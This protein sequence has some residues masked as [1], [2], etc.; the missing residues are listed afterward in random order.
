VGD[1][2]GYVVVILGT[3]AAAMLC[4]LLHYE[5][6]Y[7]MEHRFRAGA[8]RAGRKQMLFAILGVLAL[9]MA[10]IWI[11]GVAWWALLHFPDAGSISGTAHV[12]WH[13]ALFLSALAFTSLG[14]DAWVPVGAIRILT[15]VEALTGLVLVAWSASFAFLQ[16][17]RHWTQD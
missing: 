2:P 17:Q 9:H 10:E 14:F 4:V 7:R 16:M 13:G 12:Q 15:G 6:L 1:L 5:G 8:N 11:F 3:L